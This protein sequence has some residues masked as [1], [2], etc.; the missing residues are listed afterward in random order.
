MADLL[1]LECPSCGA[2]ARYSVDDPILRCDYCG[3]QHIF[4]LPTT[5]GSKGI[6][7][8]VAPATRG[9][10]SQRSLIPRPREVT[11]Q[12]TG[13]GL[14]LRWRW[15]SVKYIGLAFFCVAWDAFLCFWYSMAF[16]GSGAPWIMFVFPVAHVAVGVSL[17]YYTLAGLL[18]ITTLKLNGEQFVI[19][20]DPVPWPGEV[21][22]PITSLEQLYCKEK[23]HSSDNGASYTYQL[24]ALLKDGRKLDLVSSLD[25]PDIAVFLE[26]Q[27]ETWLKITDQPVAGEYRP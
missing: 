4:R 21:K 9:A 16:G 3:N 2:R 5:H 27:I 25:S 19:Q 1:T 15:F 12:M 24:C 7:Q 23:R 6:S 10:P 8:P 11:I 22:V 13:E 20:H 18:N 14:I 17:T 26:Q